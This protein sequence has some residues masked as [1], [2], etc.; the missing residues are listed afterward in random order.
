MR[1][2]KVEHALAQALADTEYAAV[3]IYRIVE[4]QNEFDG[5]S[6]DMGAGLM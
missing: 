4:C 1:R 3:E 2:K 5:E 6:L